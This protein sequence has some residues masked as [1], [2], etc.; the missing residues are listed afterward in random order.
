VSRRTDRPQPAGE[1]RLYGE[2]AHWWPLLSPPAHYVD[3][4]AQIDARITRETGWNSRRGKTALELGCGGGSLAFHLK[5]RFAL[6]LVD[7]SPGM[8]KVS[9]AVNPECEHRRGDMTKLRLGRQ[10]DLV[11]IHDAVM[12]LTSESMLRAALAT[13]AAH[14]RPGGLFMVLPDCVRETLRCGVEAG[15]EDAA[16]GRGLRYLEWV[17]DPDPA[18]CTYEA[19]FAF[20]LRDARG[21]T[22]VQMDRH[23]MG[24]FARRQWRQW[25]AK[26]GFAR[27]T[28][29]RDPFGRDVFTGLRRPD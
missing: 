6:T 14:C 22:T 4:A 7:R 21:R 16:D 1:C 13:A 20:L 10:F 23:V 15:G 8:L 11:L 27:V 9:R 19:A 18:D 24:V 2:L 25:I 3:E 29:L 17:T 12:Y 26:A 5:K 28:A